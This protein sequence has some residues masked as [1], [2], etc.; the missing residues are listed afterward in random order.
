MNRSTEPVDALIRQRALNPA[1]S[2][3]VSAPAGSGKTG[4]LTQRVLNLLTTVEQPENIL[5]MTFTRK[6]ADEMRQRILGALKSAAAGETASN[7]PH[8]QLTL[9]L[10]KKVLQQDQKHNWQLL[11]LPHRLRI[12]TIDGFC[13][14]LVEQLPLHSGVQTGLKPTENPDTLYRRHVRDFFTLLKDPNYQQDM[15]LL[16]RH[17]DNNLRRLEDLLV[18]MLAKRNQWLSVLFKSADSN[19]AEAVLI[20]SLQRNIEQNLATCRQHLQ[21]YWQELFELAKYAGEQLNE[22]ISGSD[23]NPLTVWHC[24]TKLLLTKSDYPDRRD[25]RKTVT[26]KEGFPPGKNKASNEAQ[27]K[28]RMLALLKD[29]TNDDKALQAL[30][31]VAALPTTAQPW[32]DDE[33]HTII[34][35]LTRLLP[36][37][38]AKFQIT[39]R[40][41]GEC[42]F[43]EIAQAAVLALGEE[44]APTD[45]ALRLDYQIK[46]ILVDEFQDTSI[47]QLD[48]LKKLTY[49][50][51]PDDGR[52]LFVVGDAMQSCYGFRDAKVGL[53]LSVRE[54]GI[55]AIVPEALDLQVN[56][57]SDAYLIEWVNSVFTEVLPE[58]DNRQRGAVSFKAATASTV[59]SGAATLQLLG[60]ETTNQQS[61]AIVQTVQRHLSDPNINSIAILARNRSHLSHILSSLREA[62]ID[63]QSQNI[64]ALRAQMAIVDLIS[65]T[66]ALGDFSDRL[67]WLALLRAPWCG[68]DMADLTLLAENCEENDYDIWHAINSGNFAYLSS[69]GKQCLQ[70]LST[71]FRTAITNSHRGS[72]RQWLEGIWLALG[73]PATIVNPL[74]KESAKHYFDLLEQHSGGWGVEDWE[75]FAS[76]L[77][78]LFANSEQSSRL[79]VMT[80]HKS[81]G[82]E[83]DV[84]I[85]PHLEKTPRSDNKELLLWED[86][87]DKDG[88]INFL[89][90]P[91]PAHGGNSQLYDYLR[92][93]QKIG[94]DLENARLLYVACT[95]AIKHLV[96]CAFLPTDDKGERKQPAAGSLLAKLWPILNQDFVFSDLGSSSAIETDFVDNF[97]LDKILRLPH[98]RPPVVFPVDPTLAPYRRPAYFIQEEL[99][100]ADAFHNRLQRYC[101]TVMHQA[102]ENA[103]IQGWQQLDKKIQRSIWDVQLRQLGCGVDQAGELLDIIERALVLTLSDPTGRWLLDNSHVESRCEWA[104]SGVDDKYGTQRV[105]EWIIDRSFIDQG[106][107]WVIDYKSSVPEGDESLDDFLQREAQ[108]YQQQLETY[109][110]LMHAFDPRYPV[111]TALYFPRLA[112]LYLCHA[113]SD[114]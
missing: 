9:A 78:K 98:D 60:F 113:V 90:S 7:N 40:E 41:R 95:R 58:Q 51:Q 49:G 20:D 80:L 71:I 99:P 13:Q 50:W 112:Q 77:D 104:L 17:V 29:L 4:L 47:I 23:E 31:D 89:L 66:K 15:S 70:R 101:G 45:L 12:Q 79:Q 54:Q 64:D 57:R 5:A 85:L 69:I 96:L 84:V 100:S 43:D 93:E 75:I 6:A 11:S 55:G 74:E 36:L 1:Q 27:Q 105:R 35:A 26:V 34:R 73:G 68:L 24:I 83:F 106:R 19:A 25:F 109:R 67:S 62:K 8:Q 32:S 107:R 44:E 91:S 48:L 108:S 37:L 39:C 103:C 82:L 114:A 2:F 28:Q 88:N 30:R 87:V 102:L 81:K 111:Q 10:A 14:Y 59:P 92:R 46:H 110:L 56:F 52:T 53:F 22:S 18:Q 33:Q 94:A 86:S 21:P 38:V 65:L 97:V 76:A 42:D 63:W 72:Y 16:L 61:D 3:A